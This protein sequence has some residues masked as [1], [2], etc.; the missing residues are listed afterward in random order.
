LVLIGFPEVLRIA[1]DVRILLYGALLVAVIRFSPQG[2][3]VRRAAS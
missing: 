3:L 2:L 1:P